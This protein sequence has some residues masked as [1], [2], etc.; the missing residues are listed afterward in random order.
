M[1]K[2]PLVLALTMSA[3]LFV[4]FSGQAAS[5]LDRINQKITQ[6]QKAQRAAENRISAVEKEM[7]QV[8]KQKGQ[9]QQ[10]LVVIDQKLNTTQ[11]RIQELDL[12]IG[13]TTLKAQDAAVQLD[14]AVQRVEERDKLLKK[15]VKV[16]YE[17]GDVS[18]LEVL[19]GA[20]SFGD[21]IDRLNAVKMII[22]QDVRILEENIKDKKL[23]EAKKQEIE[24]FLAN[25]Q[26]MYQE[27]ASLKAE[28]KKQQKER[29]VMIAQ[30]EQK[31]GELE[32]IREE[33]EQAMLDL[34]QKMKT[35]L[36]EKN[37]ALQ[38]KQFVGGKFTWPVPDSHRIT[39][40]FGYRT[41]PFTGKRTGHDGLDIGAPQGTTIV[42]AADGVVVIAGY[43][44]GYGNMVSIDHGG[45]ITSI[46]G[47]IRE[48]G[49]KVKLGQSVERGQ[50]IAEVGSTGRSTGPH[51][52][53]GVYKG[54]TLVNPLGYLQGK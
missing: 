54:R 21:F 1:R 24:A 6:I 48:G 46:Y 13:Q 29:T 3:L 16:M 41:D 32:E 10:D 42:A 38:Q 4:P 40:Q 39:S 14:A 30:L 19:L 36:R 8:E 5:S 7:V 2:T 37:Q 34:M 53:F 49:I 20:K 11:E 26:G 52:H 47:H 22:D 31:E 18:Y 44:R 27:A 12:K 43:V 35:A 51:L 33:Q 50:K 25:L 15:R 9:A 23:V 28:L 17:L 45:D